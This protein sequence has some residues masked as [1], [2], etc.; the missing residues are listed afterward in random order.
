MFLTPTIG[1]VNETVSEAKS[2]KV[3]DTVTCF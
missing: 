1:K 2:G 3:G